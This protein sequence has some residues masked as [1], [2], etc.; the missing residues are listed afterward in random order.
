VRTVKARFDKYFDTQYALLVIKKCKWA[1]FQ[2]EEEG[3]KNY[4]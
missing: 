1:P 4:K 3:E 2:K